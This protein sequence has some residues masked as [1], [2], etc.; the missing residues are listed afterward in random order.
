MDIKIKITT[1]DGGG[2]KM[3]AINRAFEIIT[4]NK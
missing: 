1:T 3:I 2:E 4:Q